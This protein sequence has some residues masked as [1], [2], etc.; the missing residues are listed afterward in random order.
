MVIFGGKNN[1]YGQKIQIFTPQQEQLFPVEN[2]TPV[3]NAK[4]RLNQREVTIAELEQ[5]IMTGYRE[6]RKDELNPEH[7][8]WNYAI[9]GITISKLELR[10]AVSLDITSGVLIIT[11]FDLGK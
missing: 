9:R 7:K 1:S 4:Y 6:G 5:V 11:V 10:V 8:S 3:E 2:H